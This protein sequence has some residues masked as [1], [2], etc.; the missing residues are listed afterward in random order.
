MWTYLWYSPQTYIHFGESQMK[1]I[2]L[3]VFVIFALAIGAAVGAALLIPKDVY[4]SQ[5]EEAAASALD[6]EVIL[7]GDVGLSFFPRIAASIEDVTVANGEGFEGEHLIKAGAL[8]ASVKWGPLLSRKVEVHEI[9]FVDADINLQKRADGQTNWAIG[10]EGAPE[11]EPATDTGDGPSID[12]GVDWARLVNASL[13]YT[14]DETGK[15]YELREFNAEASVKALALP[16]SAE[17]DGLFDGDAFSFKL[18]LASPRDLLDGN[19]TALDASLTTDFAKVN[20]DGAATLG[21]STSIDGTFSLSADSIAVLASKVGLDASTLPVA[22]SPLGSFRS[23]G[24]V[25]G[26][27][28]DLDLQFDTLKIDGEDLDVDFSGAVNVANSV[29]VNG[30]LEFT[31]SQS[32]ATIDA[33]GLDIEQAGVLQNAKTSLTG[34][35]SGTTDALALSSSNLSISG[36][37]IDATYNGA[38]SLAGG[39]RLDG[40]LRAASNQLRALA[41]A[42][43]VELEPGTTLQSFDIAGSA[44]GSFNNISIT[45]LDVSLDDLEANGTLGFDLRG[46]RPKITGDLTTGPVDFSPFL[47]EPTPNAPKGWS[48][49]PLALDSLQTV[50]ADIKISSPALTID[51]IVLSDARLSAKLNAGNLTTNIEQF[52][53]FG[54]QWGGNLGLA[55]ASGTPQLTMK[56]TGNSI[57]MRDIL[58]TFAGLDKMSGNGEFS[59]D[60]AGRGASLYDIMNSLNGD[61]GASLADGALQGINIGQLLRTTSDLR[62][63]LA[64]GSFDLGLSPSTQTDFTSFNSVL[65]VR[66]GVAQIELMEILSSTFGAN[67]LGEINLGQQSIDMALQIAGDTAGQGQLTNIEIGNVGIPLRIS[68]DWLSPS[69]VPDTSTLTNMLAGEAIGRVGTLVEDQIGGALGDTAGG[70]ISG[71]LGNALGGNTPSSAPRQPASA[72]EE[73]PAAAPEATEPITQETVQ[74]TV[75]GAVEDKVEDALEDALGGLFGRKN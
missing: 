69:I 4:K 8:R 28:D 22:L 34:N 30:D 65:K 26:A 52:N 3:I 59:L 32:A 62:A 37:L 24:N 31:M 18:D 39:G 14:D 66:N 54:G 5:I 7:A 15:V 55:T 60:I 40:S 10:P 70:A 47:G 41:A 63:S 6:R 27:L 48:K 19:S 74:E 2:V 43:G 9:A 57:L 56:L 36:P 73:A 38:V 61:F 42:A 75:Q 23:E 58:Q 20:Y 46:A 67:G 64:S 68:G 35:V 17:G 72:P 51:K 25:S 71:L 16:L 1:R 13:T 50:D 12:A 21:E 44:N 11:T 29:S 53:A 49:T 33:L 45:G